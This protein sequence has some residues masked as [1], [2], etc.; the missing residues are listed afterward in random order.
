MWYNVGAAGREA[1]RKGDQRPVIEWRLRQVL[2]ENGITPY[3]LAVE[4][5]GRVARNTVYRLARPTPP[6]RL[7]LATLEALLEALGRLTGRRVDV[8]ELLALKDEGRAPTTT[9][10]ARPDAG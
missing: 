2:R 5:S 9:R 3:R 6:A 1:P 8:G 7:D 4:L 10:G